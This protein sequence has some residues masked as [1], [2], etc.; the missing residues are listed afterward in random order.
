ML[1]NHK[2]QLAKWI[3]S[4]EKAHSDEAKEAIYALAGSASSALID[5]AINRKLGPARDRAHALVLFKSK[6]LQK[7][8]SM[9]ENKWLDAIK[10]SGETPAMRKLLKAYGYRLEDRCRLWLEAQGVRRWS[11]ATP[12]N[13]SFM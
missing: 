5:Q 8:K 2:A 9:F 4:A 13:P 7:F 11:A 1:N 6:L 12:V 10:P 3:K